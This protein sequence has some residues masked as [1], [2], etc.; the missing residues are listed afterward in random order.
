M[1]FSL[2]NLKILQ[3]NRNLT[4]SMSTKQ[5]DLLYDEFQKLQVEESERLLRSG[6]THPRLA[7]VS[8][9]P[10]E[11]MAES[12]AG[13]MN[14]PF[15]HI[16]LLPTSPQVKAYS[17]T[18]PT[19]SAREF[20]SQCEDVMTNSYV[21]EDIDKISFLRSRLAPGSKAANL[22]RASAFTEP[23]EKKDY[24]L[25]KTNF[26]QAFGENLKHN[27]VKGIDSALKVILTHASS[28]DLLEAQVGANQISTD[29]TQYLKDNGW[30]NGDNISLKNH[31]KFMEFFLYM[32]LLKDKLRKSAL[33]LDYKSTESL[34]TFSLKLKTK[35]EEKGLEE[36]AAV[37]TVAAV[38]TKPSGGSSTGLPGTERPKLVCHYCQVDGHTATKCYKRL[39]DLRNKRPNKGTPVQ[40]NTSRS[41]KS[42]D[43]DKSGKAYC[44]LHECF[45]HSTDECYSVVNLRS[46]LKENRAVKP[47]GEAARARTDDPG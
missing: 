14:M 32:T 3:F 46:K 8:S 21:T 6:K 27:L 18:D 28:L 5:D 38:S 42:A 9:P 25:F 11:D 43:A 20:I 19:F 26:L 37:S 39:R 10:T 13:N 7:P 1:L 17:G 31:Q 2:N 47:S 23:L 4:I 22:M 35:V 40:N 16:K 29:F 33:P 15:N 36:R 41:K 30:T 34:H 44:S 45:G 24:S 12:T